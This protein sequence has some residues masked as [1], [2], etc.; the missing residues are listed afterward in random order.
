MLQKRQFYRTTH[1][2]APH[3]CRNS[4]FVVPPCEGILHTESTY[5]C[6]RCMGNFC[7]NVV[8]DETHIDFKKI[9]SCGC[10]QI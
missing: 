2:V 7:I 6:F 4:L 1:R 9:M 5:L 10:V 3:I 8:K